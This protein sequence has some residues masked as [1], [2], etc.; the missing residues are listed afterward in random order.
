M[1]GVALIYRSTLGRKMVM[2]VTG[3]ML[4]GFVVAHMLGN[5]L[6]FVGPEEL[7]EYGK[8]LQHGTH[9]LIWGARGG[10]LLAVL[11]HIWAAVSLTRSNR[12][13]RKQGYQYKLEKQKTT[14][15]AITLR[16]GGFVLFCF[17]VYHLAHFTF[18]VGHPEFVRGQVYNNVVHGFQVPVVS[19]FYIVA[20][21]ALGLHL[22]H[23]IWSG[24]QT[25]GINNP[26]FNLL[27][28]RLAL[29]IATIV[30]LGN[31]AIPIAVL[32]KLVELQ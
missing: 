7:N 31:C 1:R 22:Y 10:L 24:L 11:L 17:I 14:Y 19:I 15:A 5:L 26:Q 29:A 30:V 6:V 32:T 20:M 12:A 3:L 9:G 16:Y 23:G 18:G 21:L 13:A 2:A 4:V 27:R 8:F 28:K 25:L